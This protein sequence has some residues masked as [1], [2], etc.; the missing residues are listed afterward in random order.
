MKNYLE[1][2]NYIGT[3]EFSADDKVFWGKIHGINDVVTFE[4]ASV[5][6]LEEAFKDSVDDYLQTCAELN[7][8][9]EKVFKG[10]FN[11]RV[12]GALHRS[13]ALL[14]SRKGLNINEVVKRALTYV[15]K[16]EEMLNDETVLSQ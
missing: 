6:E 7:K 13:T 4:G 15:V 12:S 14:A 16:H 2:K 10:S 1:Y 8:E 9:P 11:V 5:L 3:V